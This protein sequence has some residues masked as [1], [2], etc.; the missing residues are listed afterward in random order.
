[1]ND[2]RLGCGSVWNCQAKDSGKGIRVRV[3]T[4]LE[5]SALVL[6]SSLQNFFSR[7]LCSKVAEYIKVDWASFETRP[8][9]ISELDCDDF[10]VIKTS[11]T[12]H[13]NHVPNGIPCGKFLRSRSG[14]IMDNNVIMS[15]LKAFRSAC[16]GGSGSVIRLH[17]Y[18]SNRFPEYSI[19]EEALQNALKTI[20]DNELDAEELVKYLRIEHEGD[21]LE[22]LDFEL[23]GTGVLSSITWSLNGS[24]DIVRKCGDVLFLDST[25]NSTRYNY[26]FVTYTVVDSEGVSGAVLL[27]LTLREDF[28][29]CK[30]LL[31]CWHEAFGVKLPCVIFIDEDEAMAFS[32][33]SVPYRVELKHL[34]CT[35]HLFDMNVKKRAFCH[36]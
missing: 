27:S 34:L 25:H 20:T 22:F 11:N 32:I 16:P 36:G 12:I 2:N 15:A 21:H 4:K 19:Q 24:K 5:C 30:R 14:D 7:E 13:T 10:C 28:E 29:Y 33:D 6:T 9:T 3:S 17:L 35:Y 23:E 8:K 18:F 1:M 31:A 26:S